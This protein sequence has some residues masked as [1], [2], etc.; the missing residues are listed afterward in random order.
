MGWTPVTIDYRFQPSQMSHLIGPIIRMMLRKGFTGF[1][2]DLE[3]GGECRSDDLRLD[4]FSESCPRSAEGFVARLSVDSDSDAV[5]DVSDQFPLNPTQQ[6]DTDGDGWGD[7]RSENATQADVFPSNPT[8]WRDSDGDGYGDNQSEG[9]TMIDWFT[10]VPEASNDSDGDNYP[11]NWNLANITGSPGGLKLDACP[12]VTGGSTKLGLFGCP[13]ADGDGWADQ[14]DALPAN[15]TQW[16]D[17]DGDGFGDNQSSGASRVDWFPQ[18]SAAANDTDGDAFP[19]NWTAFYSASIA[20]ELA[21]DACP[22]RWGT[23]THDRHGCPDADGDG[24]SDAD[25]DWP[26]ALGADAFPSE[27]SQ[28]RDSDNDGFGDNWADPAWNVSRQFLW[29]GEFREDAVKSD[30]CPLVPGSS[31]GDEGPGC[32]IDPDE[33]LVSLEFGWAA[34]AAAVGGGIC[35]IGAGAVLAVLYLSRRRAPT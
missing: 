6:H 13:D 18:Q 22:G 24:W 2:A 16:L 4:W 11:D 30:A 17:S 7:N 35:M 29:P 31:S 14:S 15:P 26:S 25:Q 33:P 34:V 5:P 3:T 28:W 12:L 9:A 8:Q 19:D 23:S 20:S 1:L 32:P 27:R 21:L 10:S